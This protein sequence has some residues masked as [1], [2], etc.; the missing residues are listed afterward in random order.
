MTRADTAP[1]R[2]MHPEDR[3]S[4]L[5]RIAQK[6]FAEVG[7][8]A[9]TMDDIAHRA[10]VSRTV[11][12]RH[13]DSKDALAAACLA[14]TRSHLGEL[15]AAVFSA[16]EP[17]N[18]RDAVVEG[19]RAAFT[20]IRTHARLYSVFLA[21]GTLSASAAQTEA[22]GLRRDVERLAAQLLRNAAPQA[23]AARVTLFA[24]ALVGASER[25]AQGLALELASEHAVDQAVDFLADII[26]AG[27]P[28]LHIPHN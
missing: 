14:K 2:R 28:V 16:A 9:A 26:W 13:Y 4:Q 11:L 20:F 6:T 18:T 10:G 27:L 8:H 1:R 15:M 5:R 24:R 19:A 21:E 17:V 25:I 22:E 12:Y 7:F 23:N 3:A